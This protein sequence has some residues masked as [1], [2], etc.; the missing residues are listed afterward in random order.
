MRIVKQILGLVMLTCIMASFSQCSST[1]KLQKEAPTT[2]GEVYYEQ[3]V[4]GI[5]Q[6]P[7]GTNIFIEV[8]HDNVQLDSVYFRG[9]ATKL[10]IDKSNKLLYIG[11]FISNSTE[12]KDV[13]MH[14]DAN[15]EYD[16]KAP[17]LPAKI[18]FE[19]TPF[20]CV[21]SYKVKGKTKYFKFT[22]IVKKESLDVPM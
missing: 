10:D 9:K 18:P 6:G 22:D 16:N 21:V 19:L 1:Q 2:F 5:A 12:I 4:S 20:E 3:W 11:R 15:E 14:K 8:K 7:S 13:I 17:E